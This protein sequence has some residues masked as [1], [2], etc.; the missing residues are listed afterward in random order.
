[1]LATLSAARK[2]MSDPLDK[3]KCP[4]CHRTD[5]TARRDSV[6]PL[7]RHLEKIALSTLPREDDGDSTSSDEVGTDNAKGS[8]YSLRKAR[9]ARTDVLQDE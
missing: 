5:W 7:G 2:F 8:H 3:Q 4:L 9:D 6:T 1:M